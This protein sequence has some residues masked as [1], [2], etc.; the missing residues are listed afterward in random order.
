VSIS[1]PRHPEINSYVGLL[2][3]DASPLTIRIKRKSVEM[4]GVEKRPRV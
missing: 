2:Q 4:G 1:F 3:G